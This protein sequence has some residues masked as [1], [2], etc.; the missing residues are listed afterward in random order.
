MQSLALVPG[1]E[2]TKTCTERDGCSMVEHGNS[3]AKG[4]SCTPDICIP[5]GKFLLRWPTT[6]ATFR[7]EPRGEVGRE[8]S[9][10]TPTSQSVEIRI[11]PINTSRIGSQTYPYGVGQ[12]K[13][14]RRKQGKN[15]C[16]SRHSNKRDI[17]MFRLGET[18]KKPGTKKVGPPLEGEKRGEFARRR[19]RHEC[20]CIVR[21][22]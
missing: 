12:V 10:S 16:L 22:T 18:E 19:K 4:R 13:A 9:R 1:G 2:P 5:A 20:L 17:Y 14:K 7:K 15:N 11:S 8:G 21:T 6:Q 3:P